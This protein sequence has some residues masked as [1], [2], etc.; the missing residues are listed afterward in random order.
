MVKSSRKPDT[1]PGA[2][3]WGILPHC[4]Y[5]E[6]SCDY[7]FMTLR[8]LII[9]AQHKKYTLGLTVAFVHFMSL[10]KGAVVCVH[11]YSV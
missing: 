8:P 10:D 11:R 4:G 7:S 6:L 2:K 3:V 9:I 1:A 5:P